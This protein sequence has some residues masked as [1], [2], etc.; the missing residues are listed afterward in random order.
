M[1]AQLSEICL[2]GPLG[3]QLPINACLFYSLNIINFN[4]GDVFH[5]DDIGSGHVQHNLEELRR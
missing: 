1:T 3:E 2:S 5:G 4:A